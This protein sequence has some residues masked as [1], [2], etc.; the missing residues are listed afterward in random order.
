MEVT[1]LVSVPN[2]NPAFIQVQ[3]AGPADLIRVTFYSPAMV[4]VRVLEGPGNAG[5]GWT[6][7]DA[8]GLDLPNGAWFMSAV[9]TR[10]NLRSAPFKSVR[11]FI[12]R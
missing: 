8:R 2:P 9:A 7:L 10:E 3:V 11:I 12:V 5:P 4:K 6:T 1:G